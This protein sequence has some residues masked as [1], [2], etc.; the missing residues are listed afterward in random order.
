MNKHTV[1]H[2]NSGILFSTKRREE[3]FKAYYQYIFKAFLPIVINM[4][5]NTE[6]LISLPKVVQ[7]S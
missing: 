1:V 6:R 7:I 5:A 3:N 2:P 4:G